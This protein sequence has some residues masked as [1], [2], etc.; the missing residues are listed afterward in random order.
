MT[1]DLQSN[2]MA[3]DGTVSVMKANRDIS[4]FSFVSRERHIL[5]RFSRES[6]ADYW[7]WQESVSLYR[8]SFRHKDI[9]TKFLQNSKDCSFRDCLSSSKLLPP[10]LDRC[11]QKA[12]PR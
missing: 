10:L 5:P 4:V 12:P 9:N 8:D 2:V 1:V 3:G 7:T 6:V 11:D